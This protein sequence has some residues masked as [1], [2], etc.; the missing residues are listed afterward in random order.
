MY[1]ISKIGTHEITSDNI[2]CCSDTG[3]VIAVF[4][5]DYDLIEMLNQTIGEISKKDGFRFEAVSSM[6]SKMNKSDLQLITDLCLKLERNN[7]LNREG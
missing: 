5:N 7:T 2:L 6:I 1:E 3:R 4:Y